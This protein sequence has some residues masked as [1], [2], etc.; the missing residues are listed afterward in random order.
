MKDKSW[1]LFSVHHFNIP[2]GAVPGVGKEVKVRG[3][4]TFPFKSPS[5][6]STSHLSKPL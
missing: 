2:K 6:G 5:N 3:T 4:V 1:R